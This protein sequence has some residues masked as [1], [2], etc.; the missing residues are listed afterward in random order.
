MSKTRT[1]AL[2]AVLTGAM[3]ALGALES[4]LPTSPV[5]GIKLGL[6]N[7]VLIVAVYTLSPWVCFGM[8]ASKVLLLALLTG[9]PTM[10]LYGMAGGALSLCAMLLLRKCPGVSPIG[11]G[12]AGG[13]MHNVGQVAVA[14]IVTGTPG[15][16]GYLA[17]LLPIGAVMGLATGTAAKLTQGRMKSLWR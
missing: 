11:V 13:A 17:L 12:I 15:I 6:S 14:A 10:A 5:P 4:L 2:A 3:L 16:M 8:M 9:T 1:L 7:C